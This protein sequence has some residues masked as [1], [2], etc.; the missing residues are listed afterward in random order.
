MFRYSY[1]F[2]YFDEDD[3]FASVVNHTDLRLT[4]EEA[5]AGLAEAAKELGLEFSFEL[6]L[7]REDQVF[8]FRNRRVF[9]G[10]DLFNGTQM[11]SGILESEVL[12]CLQIENGSEDEDSVPSF[13]DLT[14]L[15]FAVPRHSNFL[16][17]TCKEY[18][19][20]PFG[21]LGA[22]SE[23]VTS[24]DWYNHC[25]GGEIH[26]PASCRVFVDGK[27]RPLTALNIES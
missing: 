27:W 25:G 13:A 6:V 3:V 1:F 17:I 26:F 15:Y 8:S 5:R 18:E 4:P 2:P 9:L 20:K 12:V 14:R 7:V 22:F 10:P 19:I 24:L 16:R 11:L 21:E 23:D